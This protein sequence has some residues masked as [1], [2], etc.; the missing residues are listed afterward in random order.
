MST[1]AIVSKLK[2]GVVIPD[3]CIPDAEK[4]ISELGRYS[5]IKVDSEG[6]VMYY[7]WSN[8]II[9]YKGRYST[10]Y[11]GSVYSLDVAIDSMRGR[12]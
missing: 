1:S 3:Q 7:G 5:S 12:I 11:C 8:I 2:Y 9:L 4:I 6:V 10:P